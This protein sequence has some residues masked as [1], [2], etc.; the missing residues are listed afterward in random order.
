MSFFNN[1]ILLNLACIN[2]SFFDS[3]PR[4]TNLSTHLS[5][6]LNLLSKGSKEVWTG[7]PTRR[8]PAQNAHKQVKN[9]QNQSSRDWWLTAC[10]WVMLFWDP[11]P[12]RKQAM[13]VPVLC[14]NFFYFL[15]SFF[16]FCFV[17]LSLSYCVCLNLVFSFVLK[18]FVHLLFPLVIMFFI[19]ISVDARN[20]LNVR[21]QILK[22]LEVILTR[23]RFCVR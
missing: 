15:F 4:S 2:N 8:R 9:T 5:E 1:S 3:Y 19:H 20:I 22:S 23:S 17:L 18:R 16:L 10:C 13:I 21:N 11:F 12:Q 7:L 6:A 14:P